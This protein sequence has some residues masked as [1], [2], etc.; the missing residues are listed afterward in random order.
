M[1]L[2][3]RRQVRRARLR[4]PGLQS[5][6]IV[7][8]ALLL[9]IV[10]RQPLLT[11]VSPESDELRAQVMVI[12]IPSIYLLQPLCPVNVIVAILGEHASDRLER[13]LYRVATV[14]FA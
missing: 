6:C 8:V 12:P 5:L 9:R 7:I 2:Q 3:G 10:A 11:S 1:I 13:L 14:R 4:W